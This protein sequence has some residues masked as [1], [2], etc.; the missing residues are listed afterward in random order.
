MYLRPKTHLLLA[1]LT[2]SSAGFSSSCSSTKHLTAYAYGY[3][4]TWNIHLYQGSQEDCDQIVN[5]INAT[6]QVLDM[7]ATS[8]KSGV[9]TLNQNG[10]VESDP[11]LLEAITLGNKVASESGGAFS[12]GIGK[13]TAAWL[14]SLDKKEV[15]PEEQKVALL[16]EA[17][18]TK[19]E[20]SGNTVK[21][22]GNGDIDF[23]AIGK[24]LCLNH[25]KDYLS[26]KGITQYLID[27]GTSSFLV[28]D[29]P[30]GN[31]VKVNLN[32]AKG[33]YFYAKNCAISASSVSTQGVQIGGVTYSHI[34]DPRTGNA[35]LSQDALYL[36]G[37]D[38]ALLDGLSTAYLVLGLDGAKTLKEKGYRFAYCK[39]GKVS[40][41]SDP[42]FIL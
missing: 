14:T 41:V 6:S 2:L 5:I 9:Y 16:E 3:G 11:F 29:T 37:D 8:C 20:V 13:L 34:I 27:G 24:G 23:G 31:S 40:D 25:I 26:E 22:T 30:D 15:L 39:G 10:Q 21:K 18:S 19:L 28:G 36:V 35:N 42:D 38:A 1:V 32:D 17:S 33:R 12:Y 4:T 7:K